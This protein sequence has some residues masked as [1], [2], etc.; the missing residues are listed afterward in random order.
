MNNPSFINQENTESSDK[1]QINLDDSNSNNSQNYAQ[2]T[3]QTSIQT[4]NKKTL[5]EKLARLQEIQ[6]ILSQ[7][8]VSLSQSMPLLE[9]AYNLK[10]EIEEEL[11]IMQTQLISLTKNDQENI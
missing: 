3:T 10:R 9:E 5:E 1:N 7:K 2:K 11:K 8:T 6:Q 4:K